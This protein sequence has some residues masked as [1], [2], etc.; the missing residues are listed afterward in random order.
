[1]SSK[2]QFDLLAVDLD[3]TLLD[4][5]NRVPERN[6]DALHRAHQAGMRVVLCTG[7]SFIETKPVLDEIGLD[8]DAAVT[9]FGSIVTDIATSR[10][11]QRTAIAM[12]VACDLTAWFANRGYPVLWLL[13]RDE[14]GFDGFELP[15]PRRSSGYDR[16]LERT[17]CDIKRV[18]CLPHYSP[19]PV[20]ISII[21]ELQVL[22]GLSD[23]LRREFDGL[24]RH[25]HL[26]APSYE[27]SVIEAFAP[28]VSKW[29]GIEALCRLWEI[30]PRRTVA[31][32]DDV[33]DID[34]L[35]QAGMSA[36]VANAL[37]EAK[38]AADRQIASNDACGVA[39]LF[40]EVLGTV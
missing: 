20:R 15:G 36:A 31:V 6:R 5:N 29:Y 4:S 13:D 12:N 7:R 35:R 3:G 28:Q 39:D 26:R 17:P 40:D 22:Y 38:R 18:T 1:M 21:D 25:N 37:P 27:V 16:W 9:A 2:R 10:T 14:A 24:L 8:L 32:G 23:D 19:E 11:I 30:D 34:M 33:N